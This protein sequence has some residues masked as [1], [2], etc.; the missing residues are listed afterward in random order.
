MVANYEFL[1]SVSYYISFATDNETR[2]YYDSISHSHSQH[3][4]E[5]SSSLP[6]ASTIQSVISKYPGLMTPLISCSSNHTSLT[7]ISKV[8]V[9][10]NIMTAAPITISSERS[11]DQGCTKSRCV[12]V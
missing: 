1:T 11:T 8:L 7:G 6:S 3:D 4:Y 12:I 2:L 10:K 5:L 9:E